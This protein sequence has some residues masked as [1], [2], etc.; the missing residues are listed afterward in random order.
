MTRRVGAAATA[1]EGPPA[2]SVTEGARGTAAPSPEPAASVKGGPASDTR[3]PCELLVGCVPC[4]LSDASDSRP[5]SPAEQSL[6]TT[7]LPRRLLAH[8]PWCEPEGAGTMVGMV[9]D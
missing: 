3:S 1:V 6:W 9:A 2:E 4:I 8:H 7:R 5:R